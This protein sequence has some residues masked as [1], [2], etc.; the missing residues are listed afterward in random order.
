MFRS[1]LPVLLLTAASSV[2]ALDDPM[3]PP[4]H[5]PAGPAQE[6]TAWKLTSVMIARNRRSAVINGE[7][8]TV[9]SNV[10]GA[11]VVAIG[12]SQVTLQS[13]ARRFSLSLLELQV[14]QISKAR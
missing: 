7:Y 8:V 2:F 13:G 10:G 11:R 3:R 12:P 9:G 6:N 14:K 5:S 1:L 4:D